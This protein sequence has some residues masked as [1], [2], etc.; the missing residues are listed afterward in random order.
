MKIFAPSS[1]HF[2]K[3]STKNSFLFGPLGPLSR[4][5]DW[6]SFSSFSKSLKALYSLFLSFFSMVMNSLLIKMLATLYKNLVFRKQK[7]L[8]LNS[9]SFSKRRLE[10]FCLIFL[11]KSLTYSSI[12]SPIA[13]FLNIAIAFSFP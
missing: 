3:N 4:K 10:Y 5:N 7:H 13:F 2:C 6:N 9:R 8:T 11:V 1:S 12:V